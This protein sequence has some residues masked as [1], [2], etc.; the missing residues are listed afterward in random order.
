MRKIAVGTLLVV[1]GLAAGFI[2]TARLGISPFAEAQTEETQPP[3]I[4]DES[5]HSPFVKVAERV[6]PAVVNISAE[7]VH[8]MPER[9]FEY[10]FDGPFD[11]FFRRFFEGWRPEM[12]EEQRSTVLGSGF[13]FDRDGDDYLILTNNHVIE[14]A[15]RIVVRLSDKSEYR[16][17][18]VEIVGVDPRTDVAV[19]RIKTDHDLPMVGLGSSEEIKVGDWCMAIGNPFT[20]ERTVTVGVISAKGRSGLTLPEGPSYQDFIQTDAAI[21]FGNS[22][23]PLV[24]IRGEVI[25]MNS[26][27][28]S[29]SGGF[30]GIGFAIPIDLVRYVSDQLVAEGK[31]VR[32]YLGILPQDLTNDLAEAYG[33]DDQDGILVAR[34]EEDTPA[35]KS[36]LK[37]GDVIVEFNGKIVTDVPKFRLIVAEIAPGTQVSFKV[38]HENGKRE[39]FRATLTEYPEQDVAGIREDE[40][41]PSEER[42]TWLGL[43]VSSVG[44]QAAGDL[45]TETQEGVYVL[46]VESDG[47]A[48]EA[49]VR[50]GDII[51]K[52]GEVDVRN[53]NDFDKARDR[54]E[55]STKPIVFKIERGGYP[56]FLAVRT[57][58]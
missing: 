2:L 54:Y 49:G 27:I 31:V 20:L 41:E 25:G 39:T 58:S 38:V 42:S 14:D 33:L 9:S 17:D 47:S 11:D 53:V 32:G 19:L 48:Y 34:V 35:E 26:A 46:E 18:Q 57:K 21:N 29:P 50:Q 6:M 13:I 55:S 10:R 36:G 15:E 7:R 23:G 3:E 44:S 52:I 40:M 37:A 8:K 4:V 22:G 28:K 5:G 56:R 12:P 45:G 24:N 51:L 30:V 1:M 43:E 16:G